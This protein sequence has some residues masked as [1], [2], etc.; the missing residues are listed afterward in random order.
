MISTEQ[1]FFKIPV[2]AEIFFMRNPFFTVC[3]AL[4]DIGIV[5]SAGCHKGWAG[6]QAEFLKPF[7]FIIK[8]P[9][10]CLLEIFINVG[11]QLPSNNIQPYNLCNLTRR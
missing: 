6:W 7:F 5:R 2:R 3:I 10:L 4:E 11:I 8:L 1:N 9:D